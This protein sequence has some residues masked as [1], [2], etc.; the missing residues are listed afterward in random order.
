MTAANKFTI[1]NGVLGFALVDKAAVGYLDAWQSPGGKTVDAVTIADYIDSPSSWGCQVTTASI[2]PTAQNNDITNDPTWCEPQSTTPNPGETSFTLNGTY[3]QDLAVS[4]DS[5]FLFLYA[6][7]IAEAFFYVGLGG[8]AAPPAAIGRCK[9]QAT[10]FAGAGQ[11]PLTSTLTIP[12]MR[13]YDVWTGTGAG[14]VWELSTGVIR[15]GVIVLG[16]QTATAGTPAVEAD[17][18]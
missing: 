2:D 5:M 6:N 8:D 9:L 10:Q 17:A 15:P 3:F 1:T 11:V 13:R 7:D 18:A 16:T 4:D 12:L 14:N